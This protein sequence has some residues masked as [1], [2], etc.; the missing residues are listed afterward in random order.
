MN[1]YSHYSDAAQTYLDNRRETT[2][3]KKYA[4]VCHQLPFLLRDAGLQQ[5]LGYLEAKGKEY[6]TAVYNDFIAVL[7]VRDP[8]RVRTLSNRD[9]ISL[10]RRAVMVA[11]SF[12][13]A[14][15]VVWGLTPDQV[16]VTDD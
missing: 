11:D 7:A 9:Y 10:S 4:A 5:T 3:Q 13:K 15:E 16:E 14:V 1:L 8:T 12:K 6:T 2:D